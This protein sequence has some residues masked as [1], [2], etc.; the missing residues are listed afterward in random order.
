MT[1]S[2]AL[3]PELAPPAQALRPSL[4]RW[5]HEGARTLLFRTPRWERL[6]AGPLMLALLVLAMPMLVIATGRLYAGDGA[7][8]QWRALLASWAD[9]VLIAWACYVLRPVPGSGPAGTAAAPGA[10]WLLSLV[11]A[12]ALCLGMLYMAAYAL[13]DR[14]GLLKQGGVVLAWTLWLVPMAW[15]VL[16]ML[17]VM[18]RSAAR[19]PGRLLLALCAVSASFALS[20]H[21]DPPREFWTAPKAADNEAPAAVFTQESAE[22]QA[23]LLAARLAALAPQ[24][25]GI[26]DMYT[27]TFAP[28]E[29]EEVFRR[30]SRMVSEVMA[31]RFDAAGRGLQLINHA[32]EVETSPWATGRNLQRAIAGLAAV[33]DRDEDLLFIHLTSHGA[34]NGELATSFWPLEV[35]TITPQ[36]LRRWLDDAGIRHRVISISACYAGS[37][38]APLASDHTLVMTAS[39][40]DHT[41]YGCGS[42]SPLTFYG[43]AMFDE[44]LRSTT[45][46]FEQA[47]AAA[48]LVIDKREKE[49]GKTD[50]YSN[51]QIK[52]G[53][54]IRPYLDQMRARLQAAG[55]GR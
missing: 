1:G 32:E 10:A 23:P 9:F 40:A 12:Q 48:R 34:E 20:L 24:R 6:A 45:L 51:P 31:R 46:S 53:A 39:D 26:A 29:G 2:A 27:L 35:A 25:R 16:A 41:S 5:L 11:T 8:F 33:M 17:V 7:Q 50:G 13:L 36:E 18:A 43:R 4:L 28:Y 55:A 42:K 38:I 22:G 49:A 15:R 52:V 3:E 21:F 44:Q 19:H 47:H 54:A 30:E 14:S 37:W